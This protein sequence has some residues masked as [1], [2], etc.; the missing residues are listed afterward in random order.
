MPIDIHGKSYLTVVERMDK[1]LEESLFYHNKPKPG[2]FEIHINK[3]LDFGFVIEFS[4]M[5]S[6][7]TVS[8]PRILAM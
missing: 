5:T 8:S 7:T 2:K 1:L 3:K 4:S 6:S